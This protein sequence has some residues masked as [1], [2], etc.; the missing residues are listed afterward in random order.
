MDSKAVSE[1]A[2]AHVAHHRQRVFLGT[3]DE[4]HHLAGFVK[5]LD[6]SV[7]LCYG[8]AGTFG[9][10]LAAACIDDFGTRALGDGHGAND[11]FD[12]FKS[13]VVYVHILDGFA[14]AGYH[15]SQIFQIAH[16]LYLLYLLEEVVEVELVAGQFAFKFHASFSS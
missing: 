10:A 15:G 3:L 4:F 14:Y 16:L 9:D 12:A 8:G 11:G 2:A 5:L 1:S 6:E 7:D 13:V